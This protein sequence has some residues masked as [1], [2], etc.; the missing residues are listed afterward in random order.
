MS[1]WT[2]TT[3][4]SKARA[5]KVVRRRAVAAMRVKATM[6]NKILPEAPRSQLVARRM[7][8]GRKSGAL[9]PLCSRR[10]VTKF[11]ALHCIRAYEPPS[12]M[13]TMPV[14]VTTAASDFEWNELAKR[15]GVELWCMR[16][17]STVRIRL[18]TLGQ[19]ASLTMR[20]LIIT[21]QSYSAIESS[22]RCLGFEKGS[23]ADKEAARYLNHQQKHVPSH[24]LITPFGILF[25][26][27]RSSQRCELGPGARSSTFSG[28]LDASC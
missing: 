6:C 1:R 2:A 3:W 25:F 5:W 4:T 24:S 13:K 26:F 17:P 15:S 22:I 21:V 27:E 18:I 9:E 16:V 14:N 19:F 20:E 12:G 8:S 7:A 23:Q 11:R 28:R 10:S